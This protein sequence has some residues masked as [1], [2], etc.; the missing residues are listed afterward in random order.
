ML[1]PYAFIVR[2]ACFYLGQPPIKMETGGVLYTIFEGSFADKPV[3]SNIV[4]NFVMA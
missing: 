3:I 1:I 2:M 4:I